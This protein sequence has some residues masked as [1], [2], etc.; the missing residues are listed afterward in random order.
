[1]GK[2]TK[3]EAM[4]KGIYAGGEAAARTPASCLVSPLVG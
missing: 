2:R 4:D 1:M 3:A